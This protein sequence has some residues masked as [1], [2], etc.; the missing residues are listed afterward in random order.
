MDRRI[1]PVAPWWHSDEILL[2]VYT[3]R[4]L[5]KTE[6]RKSASA[7]RINDAGWPQIYD[8]C[9]SSREREGGGGEAIALGG[10]EIFAS[11]RLPFTGEILNS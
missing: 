11:R 10:D 4:D 3:K 5:F 2:Y 8:A 7:F 6:S 1:L 9:I